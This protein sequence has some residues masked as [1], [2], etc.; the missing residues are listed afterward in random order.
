MKKKYENCELS[1]D[2]KLIDNQV[3]CQIFASKRTKKI[4]EI[5]GRI[6]VA[7]ISAILKEFFKDDMDEKIPYELKLD[8]EYKMKII[9]SNIQ[10][11]I[12]EFVSTGPL[13][14]I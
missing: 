4:H 5:R 6:E 11:S 14:E 10:G 13:E 8:N 3:K 2:D 9:I 7:N 12:C 1:I